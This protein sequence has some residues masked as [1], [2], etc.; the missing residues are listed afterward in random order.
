MST[1]DDY[2]QDEWELLLQTLY[3]SAEL[4]MAASPQGPVRFGREGN[5][6]VASATAALCNGQDYDLIAGLAACGSPPA[7][8]SRD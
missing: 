2:T 4:V 8:V 7:F 3:L 6:M 1:H 5:A